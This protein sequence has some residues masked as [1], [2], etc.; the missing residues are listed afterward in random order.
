MGRSGRRLADW[1]TGDAIDNRRQDAT[2]A[3]RPAR[4]PGGPGGGMPR[5]RGRPRASG[6][7]PVQ[8]AAGQMLERDPRASGDGPTVE[9]IAAAL[10]LHARRERGWTRSRGAEP[11]HRSRVRAWHHPAA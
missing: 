1:L 9:D 4:G 3:R 5:A 8:I 11:A 10:A 2:N 7:A 6:H